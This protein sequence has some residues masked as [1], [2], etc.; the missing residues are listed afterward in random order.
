MTQAHDSYDQ[1]NHGVF[2]QTAHGD[3]RNG[4][5]DFVIGIHPS[6]LKFT[7]ATEPDR[8]MFISAYIDAGGTLYSFGTNNDDFVG[9]YIQDFEE[10][11]GK[12]YAGGPELERGIVV[13]HSSAIF[14]QMFYNKTI[15]DWDRVGKYAGDSF[16]AA[17]HILFLKV[18]KAHG[19]LVLS[20]NNPDGWSNDESV[21]F[22][23][24][25]KQ[26]VGWDGVAYF[27]ICGTFAGDLF[28]EQSVAKYNKTVVSYLVNSSP[29][30][31]AQIRQWDGGTAWSQ[32]GPDQALF[33]AGNVT[34]FDSVK[35]T[36]NGVTGEYIFAALDGASSEQRYWDGVAWTIFTT[37]G[38]Y[39]I[40]EVTNVVKYK[41]GVVLYG[42]F[43]LTASPFTETHSLYWRDD[44]N[45]A[46]VVTI[47]AASD[48]ITSFEAVNDVITLNNGSDLYVADNVTD[49]LTHKFG[50]FGKYK[51]ADD[52]YKIAWKVNSAYSEYDIVDAIGVFESIGRFD[53]G[54]LKKTDPQP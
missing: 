24:Q 46:A 12:L 42:D 39:D 20:G 26:L 14:G 23:A 18:A 33:N 3:A 4:A 13:G 36:L 44:D 30:Q 37:L 1:S 9:G 47:F 22:I 17:P 11:K 31:S 10:Y 27:D 45:E 5:E 6:G 8:T 19:T 21:T 41:S 40:T 25:T 34:I 16:G 49:D 50:G 35:T 48:V 7:D 32:I 53:S 15:N 29:F 51:V 52:D 28:A 38:A 54:K 43:T 2:V